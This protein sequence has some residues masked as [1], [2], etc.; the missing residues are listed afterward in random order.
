MSEAVDDQAIECPACGSAIFP[1]DELCECGYNF[2]VPRKKAAYRAQFAVTASLFKKETLEGLSFAH[3]QGDPWGL[4]SEDVQLFIKRVEKKFQGKGKSH[5]VIKYDPMPMAIPQI[6]ARYQKA[7][8]DF[9][10]F[11]S[12]VMGKMKVEANYDKAKLSGGAIIFI[13]YKIDE[14][15]ESKGRLLILMVDRKGV[16]NFDD[17][18]VPE[19]LTSI[20]IDS[21][22]QAAMLDLTLLDE[23]YP[24]NNGEPY[25]HFITGN[26]R[27]EFFK[28]A[29]GCDPKLDNK[30]SLD[31]ASR[32]IDQF[33]NLMSLTMFEKR[34]VI[35]QY[36]EYV[37]NKA[38]HPTDK[39]ITVMA[40][41]HCIENA[42]PDNVNIKGK[43]SAY[44]HENEYKIDQYFEPTIFSAQNSAQL[45]V[46][47]ENKN[48]L[49]KISKSIIGE[50]GKSKGKV[51]YDR[52]NAEL[53]IALSD[54][55]IDAIE[56]FLG[57]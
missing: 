9:Y 20:D 22:R 30:R 51:I 40:I 33:S 27:S 28:R 38:R 46:Y 10:Q 17:K 16:F 5:G 15:I 57:K 35:D 50:K 48:Y 3:E 23:C 32:A 39:K 18:L 49:C 24:D 47:D 2:T 44:V 14:E 12:A 4:D 36:K 29:L 55:G 26:S 7:Q 54:S 19:K 8:L 1:E 21:L 42:L 43:F 6:F 45:E 31:E 25:I 41:Q 13:H 52:E 53:I 11:V 34:K 37:E 56:D